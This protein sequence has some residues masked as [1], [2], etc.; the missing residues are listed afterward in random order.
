MLNKTAYV[1]Q[2][3]ELEGAAAAV[4]WG[5][6]RLLEHR[7]SIEEKYRP[8]WLEHR[9][10]RKLTVRSLLTLMNIKYRVK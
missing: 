1:K 10:P 4:K 2:K 9:P 6:T 3:A 8:H 5:P 7:P